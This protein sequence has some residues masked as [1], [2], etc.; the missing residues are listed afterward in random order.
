MTAA[1]DPA[2]PAADDDARQRAQDQF[3]D[4]LARKQAKN[5][6]AGQRSSGVGK[7]LGSTQND[8]RQRQFRRKS[9]G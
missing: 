1:A 4:A 8:K 9:G 7:N 5:A 2:K 6:D 3:R